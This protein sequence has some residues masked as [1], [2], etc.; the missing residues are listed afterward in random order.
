MRKVIV[1]EFL[2]LDGVMEDPGGAEGFEYGGWSFAAGGD[3]DRAYKYEELFAADALLLGRTTYEA[4]AA[5]WPQMGGDNGYGD[6]MN[7]LPKY[8]ASNTLTETEW[9]ATV[10]KGD[11]ADEVTRLKQQPGQDILVFGS[12]EL[13]RSLA[14]RGLVDEYRLMI[15][16]VALGKGKRLFGDGPGKQD[17]KLADSKTFTNGIVLLVYERA[18]TDAPVT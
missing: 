16:P 15:H 18:G 2:T 11:L 1:S 17:L 13:A 10:I 12:G 9:N 6:R 7:N 4:F 5:A 14:A 8:V 3:E